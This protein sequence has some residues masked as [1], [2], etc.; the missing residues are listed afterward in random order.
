MKMR[1]RAC[2]RLRPERWLGLGERSVLLECEPISRIRF[3]YCTERSAC[4][5]GVADLLDAWVSPM[6]DELAPEEWFSG[7][8]VV[9]FYARSV[10]LFGDARPTWGLP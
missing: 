9:S 5:R 3:L 10:Q 7:G 8:R 4:F 6:R 2:G 1:C